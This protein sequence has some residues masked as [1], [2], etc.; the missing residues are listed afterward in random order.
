MSKYLET[1]ITSEHVF[2]INSN[3]I[4]QNKKDIE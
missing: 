3:K 4:A 2:V 1:H